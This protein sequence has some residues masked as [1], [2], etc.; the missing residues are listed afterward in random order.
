VSTTERIEFEHVLSRVQAWTPEMRRSL[1]EQ[2]LRSLQPAVPTAGL[3][4]MPVEQVRGIAANDRPP[5]D[6][7]TV[8]R[9][10]EDH[11]AEKYAP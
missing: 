2:L 5:P 11:R 6:D 9:W 3:R 1:A 4:G 7:D 8:K 10:I